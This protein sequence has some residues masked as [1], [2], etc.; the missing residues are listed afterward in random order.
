[1]DDF[2]DRYYMLKLNQDQVNYLN[3]PITPKEIEIVIKI[4][5]TS[6]PKN[7]PGP[8]GFSQEL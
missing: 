8:D 7:S 2:L 4:L 5:P 1:M 6:P 3:C